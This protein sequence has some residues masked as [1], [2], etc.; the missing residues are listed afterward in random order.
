LNLSIAQSKMTNILFVIIASFLLSPKVYLPINSRNRHDISEIH[1]TEIGQFGLMRKTRPNVPKHYHTGI[2]IERPSSNYVSEPIYPIASGVVISKRTDGPYANLIIE[3]TI[4]G[5][6]VWS[7]Y[8]HIAGV[9]VD[10][11]DN[12]NPN[13]P[14]ARFMSRD[15]LNKYGWQFNHF[16]LE[17]LKVK[18]LRIKPFPENP[19]RF[20]NSYSLICYSHDD[21]DK[22]YYDP[23]VFLTDNF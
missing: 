13:T 5:L 8:E 4:K 20:Y 2:D 6:K 16:H 11:D 10:V 23:L 18:P 15:E 21:L 1:I 7:L 3:H 17:I 9:K 19:Q 14:I 12:V 22:Y